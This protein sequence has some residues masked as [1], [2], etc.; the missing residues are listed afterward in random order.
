[1]SALFSVLRGWAVAPLVAIVLSLTGCG[2]GGGS[3]GGVISTGGGSGSESGDVMIA[4]TDADGDFL[5]YTV[6]VLSL[7]L[8]K[9]NG[10]VVETLPSTTRVD[11]AQ[12]VD[13]TEFLSSAS[14]P[15]G[16]YVEGSIR[17]DYSH[18]DVTVE[19]GGQPK[20][21]SVVDENGQPL[22]VVDLQIVLDN[23][24]HVVVAPGRPA[25]LQLDFD[26][27]ATHTVD[28]T[29]TPVKAT[30]RPLIVATVEPVDE[31]ELHVRGPLVSVDTVNSTYTIDVRPFL[32]RTARFGKL[33]VHTTADTAYEIDGTQYTGAA[34]LTALSQV[35]AGTS[36]A[37]FGTLNLNERTFTAARV[38]AGT[39]EPGDRFDVLWGNVT[40]RQGN[41]LT[42]RGATLI[43]RDGS[44]SFVRD[45]IKLLVGVSTRVLR[46]GERDLLLDA[47]DISI[48]Q[49][50]NAFGQASEDAQGKIT[51][52]A[53]AGRVRLQLT[54]LLGM[55]KATVP[56]MITLDLD[57]IDGRRV[58][59]FDFSGTGM[60]AGLNSDP[61]SYDVATGSLDL[62]RFPINAPTRVFGFVTPFG[63]APPDFQGRTLVDFANVR[64]SLDIG[65]GLHGTATPFISADNT[66]IAIDNHNTSI[67]LR[68]FIW[69]GPEAIDLTTLAGYP[70][71]TPAG[72]H[73]LYAIGSG[74]RV[75]VFADFTAFVAALNQKLS[76]GSKAL[77]MTARG[78]YDTAS[79][80]LSAGEIHVN[81]A[82]N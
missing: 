73:G 49:R 2:G 63:A 77:S 80:T 4:L 22:G 23:A 61:D 10:A 13:L 20:A 40:A 18:A 65:W 43:R 35:A 46:D 44:V 9:A 58:S 16:D 25:F 52:D 57:S 39:S 54:H 1:M 41:T 17:L 74:R 30:A 28:T 26:L 82:T 51:L 72:S 27:A 75:D 6:D 59:A 36:T 48:G 21:A 11:F 62:N 71:I 66:G 34:G 32:H 33:K 45:S 79:A 53:G 55:V 64:A 60:S 7:T 42:V 29:T 8:K 5:S 67:G 69:I 12:L 78:A 38:H 81:L 19:V 68:H 24:N 56:G 31:K 70:R 3:G 47:G 76:G 50:I 15:K 37:A 14:I